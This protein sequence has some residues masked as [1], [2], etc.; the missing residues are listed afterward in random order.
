MGSEYIASYTYIA[1]LSHKDSKNVTMTIMI[2][3]CKFDGCLMYL[4]SLSL[5]TSAYQSKYAQI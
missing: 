5:H 4:A 2:F 1:L 3:L